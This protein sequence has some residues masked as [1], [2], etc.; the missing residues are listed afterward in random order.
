MGSGQKRTRV[1]IA[2]AAKAKPT[3]KKKTAAPKVLDVS[4][5]YK[6][7]IIPLHLADKIS[8]IFGNKRITPKGVVDFTKETWEPT[9]INDNAEC[10]YTLA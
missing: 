8:C 2:R 7:N 6:H 4:A 9:E 10:L 3:Q 1:T 5:T